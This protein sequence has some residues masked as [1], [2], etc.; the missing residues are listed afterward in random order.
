MH[1]L[2]FFWLKAV[3]KKRIT[4]GFAFPYSGNTRK[5]EA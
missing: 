4:T 1:N 2:G 5:N 3:L